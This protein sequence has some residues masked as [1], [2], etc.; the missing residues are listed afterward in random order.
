[1][2][3]VIYVFDGYCGWCYALSPA[4]KEF[5]AA[6]EVRVIVQHGSLF[7]G[8][9]SAPI[10]RFGHIPEANA[11]IHELTGVE[12]GPDYEK[13]LAEG[14]FMLDSDGAARGLAA[15]TAVAGVERSLD[16]ASAM[17]SAFYA[18]GL[19]L[20]E[21]STFEVIAERMG[22]DAQEVRGHFLSEANAAVALR[23]QQQLQQLG[24]QSYPTLLLRRPD[25]LIQFGSPT[26]TAA[27]LRAQLEQAVAY[28]IEE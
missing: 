7:S 3:E 10:G 24:V 15:L 17:Q 23:E 11:R 6:E 19:S 21:L 4:L 5:A 9:N 8:A 20:S 25:T 22:L 16:M 12:F 28:K 14:T 26:A 2:H 18:D 27:E 13:L 1:M